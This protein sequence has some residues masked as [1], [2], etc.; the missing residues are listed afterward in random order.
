MYLVDETEQKPQAKENHSEKLR[1][2]SY[3]YRTHTCGQLTEKN[4][5]EVVVICGWLEFQRMNRFAVI[6][7]AYGHT[8]AILKDDDQKSADILSKIPLESIVQIKGSVVR[9]PRD[10]INKTLSTGSIEIVTDSITNLNSAETTLPFNVREFQ[11]AKESLR[12]QYRYLDLRFPDMQKN[13][14]IRSEVVMRM[15]EFLVRN[16]GFVDVDTPTLFRATPGGAQEFIVPTRF[17]GEFYSLVQSPQQFK[18]MLMAG[19]IDRYYQ[20]ARCYRDETSRPDRQPEFTQLDLELSFTSVDEVIALTEDLL[21]FCWPKDNVA[22]SL[23]NSPFLRMNY[24]EA[25]E[26]YGTD[27]PD[28]R[29]PFLLKNCTDNFPENIC[30]DFY[31]SY[32]KI[33]NQF[34]KSFSKSTRK[35]FERLSKKYP[36]TKMLIHKFT[37]PRNFIKS[38][39]FVLNEKSAD[40]LQNNM[41]LKEN[42]LLFVAFG[43]KKSTLQL[44]G[45]IRTLAASLCHEIIPHEAPTSIL[46]IVNWPLFEISE[47]TPNQQL[48]SCHHPFTSPQA[49]SIPL[50]DAS[51]LSALS[52][53]YDLVLN[54]NE[55]A[56]G[57]IRCHDVT[58]QR[59]ILSDVLK[60]GTEQLEG[61]LGALGS[62]CPPHGGIALGVDRLMAIILGTQ[63]IRDVIAFPKTAEGRDLLS[64]GPTKVGEDELNLY[65]VIVKKSDF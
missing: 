15:R 24:I 40:K 46:W 6:R 1:V 53:S 63:S 9:R 58:L 64:G 2:N 14:R 48:S 42:D 45:K 61:L 20:L 34:V 39:E 36:N 16:A 29:I 4:V 50:L 47:N 65:H 19:G 37:E 23:P 52:Q 26:K 21:Q 59:K 55:I 32:L 11:R 54:G 17:S 28:L 27:K 43:K 38:I 10:M 25:L 44:L 13:L 33:P 41:D 7:D 51:P 62:G 5:G 18:Q 22:V 12:M 57:S 31:A 60:L 3:T 56:G 30:D 35:E 49:T 8:Q